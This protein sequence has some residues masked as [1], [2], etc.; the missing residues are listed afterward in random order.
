M[1]HLHMAK[2]L[3]LYLV[4]IFTIYANILQDTIDKAPIG[5]TLT[6]PSGVYKG[7][8]VINKPLTIR[9]KDKNVIIQGDNRGSVVTINS[10]YV[11]LENLHITS[12]GERMEMLDAGIRLHHVKQCKIDH[13]KITNTLYGIDMDSVEDSIISNN[14]I[15][16]KKNTL[17]LRGDAIKIWYAKNNIIQN[18]TIER[19]RDVTLTYASHN[20]IEGNIFLNNRFA[21]HLEMS[22]QNIIKDNIFKYNSVGILMMGIK[23]INIT[24]NQILSSKGAAGIAVVADKVNHFHFEH[25]SVKFNAKALY[26]DEKE[27]EKGIQRYISHNQFLYNNEVFHFHSA[28]QNNIITHNIIRGNIEDVLQDL[29]SKSPQNNTI[30]Y[31]YWDRY[32]GFDRDHDNLGDT[33]Y[34]IFLYADQLWKQDNKLKFFYNTPILSVINLLSRIAPFIEPVLLLEDTKPVMALP[35]E[36][37]HR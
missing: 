31:N 12:S 28:I 32:E 36:P 30:A 35:T 2:T 19:S 37:I 16:S 23:D 11:V 26:I 27:N 33:P 20:R 24:G 9:G 22:H 1:L 29:T 25:N 13:C 4:C 17:P 15:T 3:F 18:N 6:L 10:A 34:R 8:I 14:Y 7:N 21:L 5:A